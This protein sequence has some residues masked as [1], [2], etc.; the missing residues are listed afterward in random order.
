LL[1]SIA[2][3]S[4]PGFTLVEV[5]VALAIVALSLASIG[6]LI[7]TV[8][9]ATRSVEDR[10][11]R[12]EV[13]RTLTTGLPERDRLTTGN[14]AGELTGH[15]WRIEVSPYPV[16][17]AITLPA[18]A[19]KWIPQTV[20]LTVMSPSGATVHFDTVRLHPRSIK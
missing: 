7:A 16:S 6:T 18:R 12:L 20:A 13:A 10:W 5:L 8:T 14:F 1:R 9:R 15:R 2:A 4:S 17:A 3:N 19:S 11:T